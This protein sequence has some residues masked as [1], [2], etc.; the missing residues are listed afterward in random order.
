VRAR[1]AEA[2]EQHAATAE[3]LRLIARSPTDARAVLDAVAQSAARVCGAADALIM[4]RDGSVIQ[5]VL[6]V[7][8]R[9]MS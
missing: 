2:L 9:E 1:L 6:P 8:V 7:S 4:T 3:I 5:R